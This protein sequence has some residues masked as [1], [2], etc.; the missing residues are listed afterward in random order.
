[1][2]KWIQSLKDK[3]VCSVCSLKVKFNIDLSSSEVRTLYWIHI[4]RESI[5]K[6]GKEFMKRTWKILGYEIDLDSVVQEFK[7]KHKEELVILVHSLKIEN[8]ELPSGK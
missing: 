6:I 4:D 1:M 3:C 8:K 5:T 7:T 2:S